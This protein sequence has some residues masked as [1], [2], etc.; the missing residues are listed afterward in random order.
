M[1]LIILIQDTIACCDLV[2]SILSLILYGQIKHS[3]V[4]NLIIFSHVCLSIS[5]LHIVCHMHLHNLL[6]IFQESF[7]TLAIFTDGNN[8]VREV[9]LLDKVSNV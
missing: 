1:N 7:S 3:R 2:V 9:C 8:F 5:S 6:F 4:M